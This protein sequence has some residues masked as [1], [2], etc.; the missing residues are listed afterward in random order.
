L[1]TA[2]EVADRLNVSLRTVRRLIAQKKLAIV[3]IGKAV[4]VRP[5]AVAAF[6]DEQ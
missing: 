3:R 5:E 6:I 1:L 4:R 2:Q